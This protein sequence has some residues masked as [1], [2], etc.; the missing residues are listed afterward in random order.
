MKY[1]RFKKD[2]TICYG[3]LKEGLIHL[4]EGDYFNKPTPMESTVAADTVKLLAPVTPSKIIAV[5]LNYKDHA[6]ELN[7][8][9]PAEPLIFLKPPSSIIRA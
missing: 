6:A 8:P 3:I 9:I 5:G 7:M 2:E 1:V 4:I